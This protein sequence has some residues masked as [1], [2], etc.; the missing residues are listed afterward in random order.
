[1]YLKKSFVFLQPK[2]H[3]RMINKCGREKFEEI[4]KVSPKQ[5]KI[6]TKTHSIKNYH[7]PLNTH[8][9]VIMSELSSFLKSM[10]TY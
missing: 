9:S 6:K 3:G 7:Q 8:T 2:A 5:K 10:Y 4:E 1:M